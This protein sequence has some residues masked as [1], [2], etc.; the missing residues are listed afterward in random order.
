LSDIPTPE[1]LFSPYTAPP[2]QMLTGWEIVA[3]PFGLL[4]FLP[5]IPVLRIVARARPRAALIGGG[6]VWMVATA[7]PG[8]TLIILAG[9]AVAVA[10]LLVLRAL[11]RRERIGPRLMIALV[12]LGLCAL[13]L[14][15]WWYPICDWYGWQGSRLAV[16]HAAGIAYFLL[17]LIAWGVDLAHHPADALRPLETICWLLYPPCM[18][19]GPVLLRRTFL[20]R[21]D[22]W[23]PGAPVP[24]KDVLQRAGLLVIGGFLLAVVTKQIPVVSAQT[25]EINFFAT[26]GAYAT[27]RLLRVFYLIPLQAYLALWTYNE[28]AACL[29]YWVGIRVDNNFD[30]LPRAV[31]VRDFWRR[32]HVT[33]GHWMRDYIY[34]P[35][36][37]GHGLPL[38]R[39]FAVFAFVGVWHGA[40]WSFLAWGAAQALALSVQRLWDQARK[41]LHARINPTGAWWTVV[42]WLLTMHFAIATIVMFMD[43]EHC[44]RRILGELWRR[45]VAAATG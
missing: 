34:I 36:G 11:R 4:F 5:L 3:S 2:D 30:W 1:P 29:S 31:S 13:V 23:N 35:L 8:S 24:W 10:W 27:G 20:E 40:S 45:L 21:F 44:G 7:S 18:R 38:V 14:P 9:L 19:L 43:F 6:L 37:G 32:W 16:L 28:L 26:P 17:R 39:I 33:V 22:G 41:R 25:P 12:W 15:L 42:C